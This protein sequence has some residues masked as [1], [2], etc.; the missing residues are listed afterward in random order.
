MKIRKNIGITL[1]V[2]QILSFFGCLINGTTFPKTLAGWFGFLL[3]GIIG[4]ILL[5]TCKKEEEN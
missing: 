4:V 5:V 2:L 1:I 3:C